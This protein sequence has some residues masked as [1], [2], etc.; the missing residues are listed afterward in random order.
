LIWVGRV[1]AG[2]KSEYPDGSVVENIAHP[3]VTNMNEDGV[4]FFE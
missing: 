3:I 2:L 1:V 4:A